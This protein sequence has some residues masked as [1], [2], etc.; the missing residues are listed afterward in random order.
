MYVS[1]YVWIDG[2][3]SGWKDRLIIENLAST[4][5]KRLSLYEEESVFSSVPAFIWLN[6][7][8]T[9]KRG[10][11]GFLYVSSWFTLFI[12]WPCSPIHSKMQRN[13]TRITL[14]NLFSCQCNNLISS[15]EHGIAV[16]LNKMTSV[17]L[18]L[19][20]NGYP[21]INYIFFL[22]Y[23]NDQNLSPSTL[24]YSRE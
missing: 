3:I 9:H 22:K 15:C 5:P 19:L 12:F 4:C 14:K 1:M 6:E 18:S 20:S 13:M 2:W 16:S 23:F 10:P 11:S 8:Q 17:S 24:K 21:T 7:A